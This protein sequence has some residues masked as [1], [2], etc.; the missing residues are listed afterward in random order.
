M[1]IFTERFNMRLTPQDKQIFA[2]LAKE[3]KRSESDALRIVAAEAA[4][5]LQSAAHNAGSQTYLP[6]A[7]G[8]R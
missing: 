4:A 6:A 3:L 1:K 5:R 2:F 7:E 8:Q